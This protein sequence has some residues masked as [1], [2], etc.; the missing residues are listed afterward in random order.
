MKG[1]SDNLWLL[2]SFFSSKRNN[3][4]DVDA[5]APPNE[6]LS[7]SFLSL[8]AN[9]VV[10]RCSK[11]IGISTR[12]LQDHFD[13]ELPDNIKQPP[14]HARNFLEFC[15]YKALHLA[16]SRPNYLNDNEF[17]RLTFDMMIAWE[18]PGVEND[19]INR[20]MVSCS[21]QDVEGEDGWPLFYSNS[22]KMAVQVDDKKTVGPE[23]FARIAPACLVIADIT[24][25][26]N[27]FDVL[28]SSSGPR[29]HFLIYNKYLQSLEK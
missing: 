7:I 13:K 20:E 16:T 24:T 18:D 6:N 5:E 22:T 25:V 1:K 21:Y 15:S 28:T 29:L 27:L 17:R 12:E 9:Y 14:F 19:L 26:H 3:G 11:I 23:A 4:G 2:K 10:S 8:H